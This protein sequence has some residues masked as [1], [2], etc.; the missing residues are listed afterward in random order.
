M[1][2]TRNSFRPALEA[3]EERKLLAS[4][5]LDLAGNVKITGT[6][7]ADS[8]T[9]RYDDTNSYVVVDDG[10]WERYFESWQ[11]SKITFTGNGGN[12]FFGNYIHVPCNAD[13]G[14]GHDVLYGNSGRD[15]L[16]GGSGDDGLYGFGGND[17]MYGGTGNDY[18]QGYEGNDSLV[19][20]NG[21]DTLKGGYGNDYLNGNDCKYVSS[22]LNIYKDGYADYLYGES[23]ADTFRKETYWT[24][25]AYANRDQPKDY[26]SY[27]GD[28][29]I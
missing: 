8:V 25:W 23:G 7:Y 9:V 26:R 22:Y 1:P 16:K 14:S 27:E 21:R 20:G 17:D 13:G 18:L 10:Q 19:G 28:R 24:G 29:Y 3:L 6:S 15:T 4:S 11:V 12:D 5:S 2:G